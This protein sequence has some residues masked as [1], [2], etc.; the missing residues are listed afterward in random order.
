[1]KV[2][3]VPVGYQEFIKAQKR[4][5]T[6][7]TKVLREDTHVLLLSFCAATRSNNWLRTV[8]PELSAELP[9]MTSMCAD[10]TD[11]DGAA[12]GET[13]KDKV[14]TYPDSGE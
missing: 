9:N 10:V 2:L 1:M 11:T 4:T 3:G 7:T 14:R 12:L 5:K 13:R 8:R 6:R